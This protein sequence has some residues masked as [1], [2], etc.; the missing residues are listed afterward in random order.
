MRVAVAYDVL[1]TWLEFRSRQSCFGQTKI[2]LLQSDALL[3]G[4]PLI[5]QSF[6][7]Q[8]TKARMRNLYGRTDMMLTTVMVIITPDLKCVLTAG[9]T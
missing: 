7:F 2:R 3:L 9:Q 6:C 4:G 8:G 1:Q 5:L